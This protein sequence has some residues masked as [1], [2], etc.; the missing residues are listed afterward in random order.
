MSKLSEEKIEQLEN[1]L[2]SGAIVELGAEYINQTKWN[3]P[4]AFVL[5]LFYFDAVGDFG[6][7]NEAPGYLRNNDPTDP[8]SI[9]HL[10]GNDFEYWYD[11]KVYDT[12][13]DFAAARLEAYKAE[14]I[15]KFCEV[16]NP[17]EINIKTVERFRRQGY[18][19]A[20]RKLMNHLNPTADE[21]K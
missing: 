5:E 16:P 13:E 19:D 2:I 9:Y 3:G 4:K 10:F 12:P 21:S 6:G 8:D 14:F 1:Q 18:V 20:I 15:G 11:C 17:N 7:A